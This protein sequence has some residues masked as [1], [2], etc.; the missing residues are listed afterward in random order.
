MSLLLDDIKYF[1]AA[2]DTLNITRASEIIGISQPALSYSIKRLENKLGGALFI[3]LKNGI[4]LTKLGEE[5]K[6]RSHRLIYEWEQVQN[7]AHP[8]SGFVQGNYTIALHP[9]VALYALQYFMP[10]LQVEYP[11]LNFNFIHGHSREMTEK[12]I[13]WEADFGIVVNPIQHPDLVIIKL[14]TDEVSVFHAQNA[15]NK[16]IYDKKLA[17]SQYILKKIDK[18]IAFNGVI[19]ST[20]LEVIAKLT[21]LG[22]GY[23]IL[24]TRVTHQYQHLKKLSNAP[25]FKDEICLVYRPEKHNNLVSKKII[26]MI[27]AS[28]SNDN[29]QI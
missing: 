8:E 11:K 17:Q 20:S 3:R 21:A 10:Q 27:R 14:S 5:F 24:P 19:N 9:S 12:V 28:I 23:G 2:S 15:Q 6:Q 13:S 7:I 29:A 25:I 22:L 26:Q 1:I 18:K 16:L 4:Q